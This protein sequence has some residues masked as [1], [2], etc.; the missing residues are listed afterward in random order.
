MPLST[1]SS[2]QRIPSAPY[3]RLWLLALMI[4]VL[5]GISAERLLKNFGHLKSVADGEVLWGGE[6]NK[7]KRHKVDVA[8]VGA[9]RMRMGLQVDRF[10]ERTGL[11]V[12]NVS[13]E[14]SS[15]VPVLQ[16]IAERTDFSGTVFVALTAQQVFG[17]HFYGKS[18]ARIRWYEQSFLGP[19]KYNEVFNA[20]IL[21]WMQ[22]RLRLF[23][24]NCGSNLIL[25]KNKPLHYSVTKGRS[26]RGYYRELLSERELE[27]ARRYR[28]NK[29]EKKLESKTSAFE[30]GEWLRNVSML[31]GFVEQI[32]DRG[33]WVVFIRFPTT[34]EYGR[35]DMEAYPRAVYWDSM[36]EHLKAPM[37]YISDFPEMEAIECP[38]GSHLNYDD[39]L[40]VTDLVADWVLSQR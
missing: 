5:L 7:I 34:G 14:G 8:L 24:S 31:A 32:Q 20:K 11:K 25:M 10:E 26:R 4:A 39:S 19:E 28:L 36:K 40:K 13:I 17:E 21:T 27:E 23:S 38:E 2:N 16:Y 9:S 3:G 37:I 35:I 12:A 22:L 15:S 29:L 30:N 6:L 1:S 18:A 33:G